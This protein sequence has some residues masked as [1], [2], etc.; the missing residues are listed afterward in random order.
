MLALYNDFLSVISDSEQR[1]ELENLAREDRAS[2][3]MYKALKAKADTL[4]AKLEAWL[5][6]KY[7][8]DHEI[9]HALIF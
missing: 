4:S 2:S 9:H 1:K 3:E 6:E 8:P 5:K 7:E